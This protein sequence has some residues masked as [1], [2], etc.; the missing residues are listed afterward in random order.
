MSIIGHKVKQKKLILPH[1]MKESMLN[2]SLLKN[3]SDDE[4]YYTTNNKIS[5]R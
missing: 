1:K 5:E 3:D 4:L 2:T